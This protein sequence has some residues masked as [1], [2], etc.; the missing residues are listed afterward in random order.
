MPAE[1]MSQAIDRFQRQF[2]FSE[3]LPELSPVG[4]AGQRLVLRGCR[5]YRIG[6]TN[7]R[8]MLL[9]LQRLH[10]VNEGDDLGQLLGWELHDLIDHCT[11]FHPRE[12]F[13]LTLCWQASASTV[14]PVR[15]SS[16]AR[17]KFSA[18]RQGEFD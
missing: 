12:C 17:V 3:M 6:E 13:C 16:P 15:G 5:L 1:G 18:S 7:A 11:G 9:S 4:L 8:G 14:S 2:E 10:F